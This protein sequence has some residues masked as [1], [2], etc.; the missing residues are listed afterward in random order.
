MPKEYTRGQVLSMGGQIYVYGLMRS[1]RGRRFSRINPALAQRLV[2]AGHSLP[3]YSLHCRMNKI[4]IFDRL[5]GQI[6]SHV[7]W[8]Q[9][10][11]RQIIQS[12]FSLT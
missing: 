7:S 11:N 9:P 4:S 12:E 2:L 1:Q 8:I 6:R 5:S 10:F 3:F